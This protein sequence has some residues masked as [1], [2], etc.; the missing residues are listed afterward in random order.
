MLLAFSDASGDRQ[1]RRAN[2]TFQPQEFHGNSTESLCVGLCY[3]RC[4]IARGI[5]VGIQIAIAGTH[6]DSE[7]K[8][9]RQWKDWMAKMDCGDIEFRFL[10]IVENTGSTE[11]EELV[12]ECTRKTRSET[13]MVTPKVNYNDIPYRL[14]RPCLDSVA[15]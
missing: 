6:S 13:V 11:R 8:F 3:T 14:W 12:P 10:W 5:V 9:L 4:R 7:Q 15:P 2:G 1:A